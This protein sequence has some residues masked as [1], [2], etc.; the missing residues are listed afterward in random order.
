MNNLLL[1][2]TFFI[3][4]FFPFYLLNVYSAQ[5]DPL[6][7]P[8]INTSNITLKELGNIFWPDSRYTD[9]QKE[10][11][12]KIIKGKKVNWE[13]VISQI[14]R[15]GTDY[16]IQG[17]SEK[18][19]IGTFSYITPKTK[20]EEEK[21]LDFKKGSTIKISGIIKDMIMRHIVLKPAS[22]SNY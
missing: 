2:I 14:Q 5:K 13:I 11:I 20:L 12:L 6:S 21:I 16:L 22:L 9:A 19:M 8:I 4:L 10:K 1:S 15:D 7:T 17:S 3:F 18:D